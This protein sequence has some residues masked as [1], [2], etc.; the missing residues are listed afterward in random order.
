[1]MV[2]ALACAWVFML[3]DMLVRGHW[4]GLNEFRDVLAFVFAPMA[5]V[6][7]FGLWILGWLIGVFGLYELVLGVA[8]RLFGGGN[9][10]YGLHQV[11]CGHCLLAFIG[12][13]VV[14]GLLACGHEIVRMLGLS[15]FVGYRQIESFAFWGVA[16]FA[17]LQFV[18]LLVAMP[19]RP[20]K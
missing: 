18:M 15:Q 17:L 6:S 16:F 7:I 9:R 12:V 5:I 2:L 11:M 14:V 10:V 4:A 1:M 3:L 13:G 19:P 20:R 8:I